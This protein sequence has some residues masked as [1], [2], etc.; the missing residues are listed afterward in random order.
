VSEQS[1]RRQLA[2]LEAQGRLASI[3]RAVDPRADMAAVAQRLWRERG[4]AARF[5]D[6]GGG[7]AATSHAL[8]GR[9]PWAVALGVSAEEVLGFVER[10]LGAG[11]PPETVAQGLG[12]RQ[13]PAFDR[14]PVPLAS[15]GDAAPQFAAAMLAIDPADGRICLG[16]TRHHVAAPDRLGVMD[17][18]PALAAL[19]RRHRA[20]GRPMPVALALGADPALVLA[21]AIGTWRRTDLDLAGSLAGAPM[22]VLREDARAIPAEAELVMLGELGDETTRP[23]RLSTPFGTHAEDGPVPVLRA[24]AVLARRDPIFHATCPG[25][26]AGALCL[27]AEALTLRHIRNIEGGLD[28]IDLVSPAA[29]PVEVVVVKLRPRLEGQAK[30]AL[31]GALSGPVNS[32]KLAVAVDEDVD[33]ADLRDV[34]WSVASRTHAETDVGMVGGLRAHPLDFASPP[35]GGGGERVGTRWFVDSTMPPLTQ[36][37]RREAFARAIPKN[38]AVTELERFLPRA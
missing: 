33:P 27:A 4:L 38:L 19:Y 22:R 29:A 16:L 12:E 11:R 2:A 31:M 21:A 10:A 37:K 6:A 25:D 17:L 36:A 30:T 1:I 14:W 13:A 9:A 24:S 5:A 28:I 23:G 26:L 34:F 18:S 8:A 35:T 20:E 32:F 15:A 3:A 7:R